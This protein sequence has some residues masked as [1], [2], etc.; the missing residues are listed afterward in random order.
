MIMIDF[1]GVT[2][3]NFNYV[4]LFFYTKIQKL[5]KIYKWQ[6]AILSLD[7]DYYTQVTTSNHTDIEAWTLP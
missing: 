1:F 5:S 4:L 3:P 7:I 6:T 2:F